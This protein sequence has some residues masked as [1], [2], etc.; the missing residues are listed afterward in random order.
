MGFKNIKRDSTSKMII[1]QIKDQI[2]NGEL[3]AGEKLPTERKLAE[4][5][6][7][8]RTSVREAIQA[9][10]FS[11][12]LDVIQGK[13]AFVKENA[14]KYDEMLNLFSRISDFSLPALMEVR[15]MFES[16]FARLAALRAN[17][18][19][20]EEIKEKFKAMKN[21]E[22]I[23]IFIIKDLEFHLSIAKATHNPLMN[24]LMRIFGELLHQ[25]TNTIKKYSKESQ[26]RTVE[27]SS[28]L[29]KAIQD[30]YPEKA[31]ELMILHLRGLGL[32]D[33]EDNI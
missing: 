16:E 6:G 19:N 25:E 24:T 12:Y 13:G 7:I 11:G 3:E 18:D 5:L 28:K 4:L 22:N 23:N 8:S 33:Y 20:I 9:L 2:S 27:T 14:S 31:S 10:A 17:E 26:T 30:K 1:K 15:I 32:E 29:V 21:I